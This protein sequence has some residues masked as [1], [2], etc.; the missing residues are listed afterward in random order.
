MGQCPPARCRAPEVLRPLC[1]PPCLEAFYSLPHQGNLHYLTLYCFIAMI[2][3]C[4]CVFP[5]YR[6]TSIA[7]CPVGDAP[8]GRQHLVSGHEDGQLRVWDAGSG[9]CLRIHKKKGAEVSAITVL[10]RCDL[11][12]GGEGGGGGSGACCCIHKKKGAEVLKR[13]GFGLCPVL[14][15]PPPSLTRPHPPP[16]APRCW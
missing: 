15:P 13:C 14:P 1:F 3:Y 9:A 6:A 4:V 5:S 7:F 8:L 10:E 2:L 11:L 16:G 12:C